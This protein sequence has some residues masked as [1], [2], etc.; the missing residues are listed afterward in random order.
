MKT[1]FLFS[2]LVFVYAILWG[3]FLNVVAY[4]LLHN[5]AFFRARSMCTACKKTLYWYDLIPIISWL[6]LCGKCRFCKQ[7]I[8]SLYPCIELITA[9]IFM[10]MVYFIAPLYWIGYGI[11][12]SALIITIRT[13]LETLSILRYF[14][15]GLIPLGVVLSIAQFLPLSIFASIT[16]AFF[17]YSLLWLVRTLYKLC[18][19]TIGIGQGDLELLSGIGAFIGITGCWFTLLFGSLLGTVFGLIIIATSHKTKKDKIPFGPCLALGAITFTLFQKWIYYY[20]F[21]L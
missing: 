21:Y 15:L 18:T 5:K 16:G 19:N 2:I 12:F 4:R 13:D 10:L 17:G 11:F 6:I 20:L 8:S 14:S 1:D 7:P 3:S 9:L